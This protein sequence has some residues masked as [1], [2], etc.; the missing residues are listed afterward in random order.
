[1]DYLTRIVVFASWLKEE[2][3]RAEGHPEVQYLLEQIEHQF[4]SL[5]DDIIEEEREPNDER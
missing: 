4:V 5:F 1:M 2:R 3:E